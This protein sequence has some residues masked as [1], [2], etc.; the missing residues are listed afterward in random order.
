MRAVDEF[1]TLPAPP[2]EETVLPYPLG[3]AN[4]VNSHFSRGT[5]ADPSG[6]TVHRSSGFT[7]GG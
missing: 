6:A 3:Q 2:Q 7:G 4:G 1:E 5:R